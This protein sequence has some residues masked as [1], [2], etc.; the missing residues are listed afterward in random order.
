MIPAAVIGTEENILGGQ[1]EP[2][3]KIGDSRLPSRPRQ[4]QQ[5]GVILTNNCGIK[6]TFAYHARAQFSKYCSLGQCWTQSSSKPL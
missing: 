4:I 3:K 6:Q 2:K 5:G 1:N